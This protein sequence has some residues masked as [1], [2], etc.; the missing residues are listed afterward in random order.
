MLG[1][2]QE[3]SSRQLGKQAWGIGERSVMHPMVVAALCV[4][5]ITQ[6]KKNREKKARGVP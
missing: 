4:D 1:V 5:E 2:Y 6:E 3:A